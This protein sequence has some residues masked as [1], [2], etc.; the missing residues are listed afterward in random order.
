MKSITIV[1][2]DARWPHFLESGGPALII[3]QSP[4]EPLAGF[5]AR[6][7]EWLTSLP[8]ETEGRTAF[9]VCNDEGGRE[10]S[11]L[12]RTLLSA[13][14]HAVEESGGGEVIVVGDG[15]YGVRRELMKLTLQLSSELERQG[16]V[17]SLRFRAQPR[18]SSPPAAV[19]T[20]RVA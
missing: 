10:V 3:A 20:R 14:L 19:M 16:S 17:V 11:M 5:E 1:Q 15:P 18:Q 7:F 2:A 13:L 12:R 9:L 6:A 4:R 8:P